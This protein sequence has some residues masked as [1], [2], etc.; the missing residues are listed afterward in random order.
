MVE[1]VERKSVV[2]IERLRRITGYLVA[3]IRYWG[4]AK[5]AELKDRVKHI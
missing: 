4:D 3:D 2:E 1:N 5:K